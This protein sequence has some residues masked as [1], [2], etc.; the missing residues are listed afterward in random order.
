MRT[1]I[2]IGTRRTG[3]PR[4]LAF[5]VAA[6]LAAPSLA[7]AQDP[8]VLERLSAPVLPPDLARDEVAAFCESRIP[9][10]AL[11]ATAAE[12]EREAEALRR[13]AL[14][15]VVFRGEARAWRDAPLVVER[16]GEAPGGD[17]FRAT[18]LRFEAV[19][20]M[21]I[22]GIL[23]E[24]LAPAPGGKFPVALQVNGHD[25]DGKA[26]PYK[27]ARCIEL[28]R[29]GV[30]SLNLEWFGMGQLRTPG[31]DHA[32]MNQLDLCGTAGIAP[33]FLAMKRGI[34]LLLSL[35]GADP[36]RVLVAGLSGGG[37]QTIFVSALDPRAT[38]ANPVAGY[39][40][41]RTR[42]RHTSDLGDSEQ[43]P[44]DLATVVDYTHLTAMRAPRPTLLTYN[45]KDNCCFA[46]GHA[47]PP[48]LEAAAPAF[49]L[50]GREDALR[51]HVN[52]D[53]GDHNFL[54]DNREALYRA[55]G[56]FFFPNDPAYDPTE[57]LDE[58]EIRAAADLEVPLPEGNAD[59]HSLALRL[60]EG[61]PRD[62]APAP[63]EEREVWVARKRERLR[64]IVRPPALEVVGEE[65]VAREDLRRVVARTARLDMG[66]WTAAAL[67]VEPKQP[68]PL[69][70]PAIMISDAGRK[71]LTA[72]ALDE[73]SRGRAVVALDPFYFG[74]AAVSE[75]DYLYAILVAATGE[76]PLGIQV[77]Q[78]LAA[79]RWM[80]RDGNLPRVEIFAEGPRS[81]LIARIAAAL[82]PKA[83]RVGGARDEF[84]RLREILD[85]DMVVRDAPELF[86]FG[87]LEEF[88]R[89]T[90]E[91]LAEK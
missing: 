74:E 32:R 58:S 68:D 80:P 34:D 55:V 23:Y 5:V 83:V 19:P 75:R 53:P 44:S 48:L 52:D 81:S 29:R 72:R 43:T 6:V 90:L 11:P 1:E 77:A 62:A 35:E 36:E 26:A 63:G 2:P 47:L 49:R 38:L 33:F 79:A 8:A 9:V 25:G 4:A 14:D 71:T 16:L 22:P 78:V 66:E 7:S 65:A 61:L 69:L 82:D 12:W 37:W 84:P 10:L 56:D 64:A 39:S 70:F 59:F 86:C 20:G 67:A 54:R 18:K 88:E 27:Q 87:L 91:A 45:A 41:F 15:E 57:R 51:S 40:S 21:W 3:V 46:A 60:A 73:A 89:E 76:R 85:R 31:F 42:A 30:V 17:G 13:R 28:A 24:P 50:F